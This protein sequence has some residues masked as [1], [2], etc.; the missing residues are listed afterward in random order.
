MVVIKAGNVILPSP[1]EISTS[2]EIIWSA[3]TGRSSTGKMIG[4]VVA[5][6]ETFQI[7]W[8]VLTMSEYELIKNNLRSGF[9][10]FTLLID[11]TATTVTSYRGTLSRQIL[12]T[13]GGDTYVKDV[14]VTIIQQ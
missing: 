7:S 3:N 14:N 6:K 5:E 8:G 4:D 12:G 10:P 1:T 11:E 9:I 2:S 13:F